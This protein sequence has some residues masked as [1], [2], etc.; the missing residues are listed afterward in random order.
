[1]RESDIKKLNELHTL[2]R[3]IEY[4]K[5][6]LNG[7]LYWDKITKMPKG[8]I[9]YRSEVMAHFGEELYK[10]FSSSKLHKLVDYFEKNY[11]DDIKINSM[12][13]RIKRNYIYV[14]QIPKKMYK[15]Y[16]S[17]ISISEMVWQEA[18]EKNDFSILVPYLE[19]IVCYFKEFA[20]CWGY[21]KDPYDALIEYYEEG[22]NTEILDKLIPDLKDF[23]METLKKIEA[24]PKEKPKEKKKKEFSFE[25]QKELSERILKM[26]GF[27]FKY[28]RVDISEHPT[29][30]ANS[31]QDVR[32]VTTFSKDNIFKGIYNTLHT[33]GKGIYEQDI[34][35]NLLGTLL[36]EVSTFSLEETEAKIYENIVGKDKNF[37]KLLLE[38]IKDIF[39]KDYKNMT[40]EDIYKK[41]NKVESSLIRIDADELTSILHIIIRYEIERDL[42]NNKIEVKDLPNIWKSKYKEYLKI[43]P[44]EDSNGVLQDIH[45]VAGYFGY[46]PSY[47]L[48]GVYAGQ[49][50][51]FMNREL[52]NITENIDKEKLKEIH[53][54]LKE[55]IHRYGAI[56]TPK[57]LI[58]NISNEEI[59]SKYYIEYLKKKYIELYKI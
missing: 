10:K 3:E 30:L 6:T 22:I 27:D 43:E 39:P 26:I 40:L 56:Y 48:S 13:R 33:G 58:M 11:R 45:W 47:L 9:Y 21:K 36:G 8:G 42:I 35:S 49:I 1:M 31:P 53:R 46:F 51:A 32:I 44:T 18:K 52:K 37:C 54:W 28:G 7:L 59:D 29:T 34:D 15:E 25:K 17:H 14:N 19:K 2:L 50:V 12:L 55:N 16:I 20:E 38:E 4:I 24:L 5:Y 23:A 41:V 57:E